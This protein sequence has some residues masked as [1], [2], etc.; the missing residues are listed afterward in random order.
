MSDRIA[1]IRRFNRFYTRWVGALQEGLLHSRFSLA[2]TRVLYELAHRRDATATEL[3]R[4]LGLDAG[5]LS[6]ILT[7]FDEDGLIA[8]APSAEDRRRSVLSLTEAGRAA[9]APLDEAAREEIAGQIA[10]LAAPAQ[11]ELVG[12]MGR[13]EAL[14]AADPNR[15]YV[16]RP[17]RAGDI[18][19]VVARHGA[20]YAAEYGFDA[21]FEALVATVAGAFLAENDPARERCWIAERD[22]VNLGSIFLVRADDDLAKLRLLLVEPTARGA[23]IGRRLVEECLAFA[24]AAGYRRVTLWTNDVL[25]A[26]R[27]IYQQAGFRL[28]R[29]EPHRN[30]GPA[31]VGEDWEKVLR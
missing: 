25:T 18:G 1:A 21:R 24:R 26:A 19:W 13:I 6:R 9:F 5:Y 17:P 7:R 27:R 16:I 30:F 4:D 29:S 10:G 15:P 28:I 14:L 3:G 2:E 22:G 12:A 23:G 20:L 31:I 11:D 8:R